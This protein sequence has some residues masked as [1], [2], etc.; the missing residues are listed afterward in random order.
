MINDT[1]KFSAGD[2][3]QFFPLQ[4]SRHR[5]ASLTEAREIREELREYANTEGV[6][7]WNQLVMLFKS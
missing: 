1:R 4:Q 3:N 7:P 2:G 5:N 6:L